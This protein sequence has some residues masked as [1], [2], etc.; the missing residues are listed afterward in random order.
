MTIE[1]LKHQKEAEDKIEF[2]AATSNFTHNGGSHTSQEERRKCYLGYIVAFANE[3]GGRLVLGMADALPHQVVGTNFGQGRVGALEDDVYAKLG[4]RIRTEELYD[5]NGFRVLVTHIPSRPVGKTLKYEG[6]PLMRI[7]ESLRNMSDEE[8]FI[9][10]SEQ[11]PDFSAKICEGLT[12]NDLD[13]VA[14]HKLKENFSLKQGNELFQGLNNMQ[15]LIDLGLIINT[16]ITYAA[17]ILVGKTEIIKQKIPQSTV[18][19]EYRNS[20]AQINFDNRKIVCEPYF[21]GIEKIWDTIND[22][23]GSIPVQQGPKIFDIPFFNKEVIREAINNAVV[24]RSYQLSS[25]VVIKQFSN[26]IHI[27]NPGGFPLGVTI[28]NLLTAPST[29]RNRLLADILSKTGFVERSGQ[30]VDKIY[31]QTVSEGKQE[32][33]YKMSDNFKVEL[34]LSGIVE[35]KAFSIFIKQIQSE[36]T[37]DNKLSVLDVLTLNHI[38]KGTEKRNLKIDSLKKL[39]GEFLIERVGKT[40]N[41]KYIL[42]KQYFALTNNPVGYTTEKS[43]TNTQSLMLIN[44]HLNDF[45]KAKMNDFELLLN[46]MTRDQVK[47]FVSKLVEDGFLDKK[48]IGRG[49]TYEKGVKL[50]EQEKV[51]NR[52]LELGIEQMKQ[53]G[54]LPNENIKN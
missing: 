18:C 37:T 17:V 24:H 22:R 35:D 1:Q 25:E 14:I 36:R 2:K 43:F 52:A 47:Y 7:G 32:P 19:I 10:L 26:E 53:M 5:A 48:G 23:N 8:M 45:A 16:Q 6:V 30:G 29:P 15:A 13:E 21:L 27:I 9:I 44:K 39:E 20:I 49:T 40:S 28:D 4:I 54:E 31:Y 34:R 33:D 38:R 42:C 3:G 46:N 12:I 11:E 51:F 41:Q 50:I